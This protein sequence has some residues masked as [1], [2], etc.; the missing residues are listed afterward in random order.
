MS[1][2]Y[3]K[4]NKIMGGNIEQDVETINGIFKSFILPLESTRDLIESLETIEDPYKGNSDFL[5]YII[6]K[7]I[8]REL[9]IPKLS[10]TTNKLIELFN[11]ED[12]PFEDY[13]SLV[14]LEPFIAA[15]IMKLANSAFYR[16]NYEINS[17][18]MAISRLGLKKLKEIVMVLAFDK[19]VFNTKKGKDLVLESW[20]Y[21]IYTAITSQ[22]IIKLLKTSDINSEIIYTTSLLK[23]IGEFII[24]AFLDN[25]ISS[26]DGA[27]IPDDTFIYRIINSFKYK[28][29]SIVL[30]EWGFSPEIYESI[31]NLEG[32]LNTLKTKQEKIIFFSDKISFLF[33][34]NRF[35]ALNQSSFYEGL[36]DITG[37]VDINLE[38]LLNLKDFLDKEA[39]SIF[40]IFR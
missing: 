32:G 18:E 15:K 1:L 28:I 29:S 39:S 13:A 25:Y 20:K 5:Y 16:G 10:S 33:Y 26:I 14:K 12:T 11:K 27:P 17:I 6:D 35:E 4:K 9:E 19:V 34:K 21:S 24:L 38:E 2:F 8:R 40:S 31:S 37:L 3:D 23:G 7:L 30:K 22:E 36:M